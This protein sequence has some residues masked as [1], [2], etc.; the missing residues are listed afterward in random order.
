MGKL[1]IPDEFDEWP[2]EAKR[3]VLAE[4]NTVIDLREEIETIVGLSG[5]DM[6][7]HAAGSFT[8]EELAAIV[9]ALGGPNE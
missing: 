3:F 9:L 1:E 6:E 4:A 2:F 5:R 7:S 8:K